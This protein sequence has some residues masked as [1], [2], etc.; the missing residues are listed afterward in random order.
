MKVIIIEGPDN[1]GKDTLIK[2]LSKYFNDSVAVIHA[3]VPNSSN[4]FSYYYDGI[5][6]DTL[7]NY[8]NDD[9]AALIHNRS[10]YGEYVY[11]PKYRGLNK[12]SAAKL[13]YDLEVDQ[14]RT[15]IFSWD[16][17][18]ILL[19]SDSAELLANNDD[20]LSISNKID[21]IKDEIDQFT[22]VFNLST[23]K[24]KKMVKV[25]N[26]L[27]FRDCND[28]YSEVISFIGGS[29]EYSNISR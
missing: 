6:H 5:I 3:G 23:I 21:D 22:E 11:G 26:G 27:S 13:I 20:G 25:N 24:N 18:F 17:Y 16:L 9:K 7:D 1:C 19:T 2:G 15:F 4:L 8:Y 29:N 28:I 12:S 14:L 10:I